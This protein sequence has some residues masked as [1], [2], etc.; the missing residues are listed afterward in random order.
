MMTRCK[1]LAADA[2]STHRYR[3]AVQNTLTSANF[4]LTMSPTPS[5]DSDESV[6][7]ESVLS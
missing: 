1:F 6:M 2:A 4:G 5:D 3:D 7:A